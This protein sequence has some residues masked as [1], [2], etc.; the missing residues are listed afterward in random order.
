MYPIIQPEIILHLCIVYLKLFCIFASTLTGSTT[1]YDILSS[2][3]SVRYEQISL[4]SVNHAS[5]ATVSHRKIDLTP[6][7]D[8]TSINP[9]PCPATLK[10]RIILKL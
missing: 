5:K 1:E 7:L 6:K 8:I 10:I 4:L 3:L 9:L 2:V